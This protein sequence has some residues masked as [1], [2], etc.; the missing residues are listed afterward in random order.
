MVT[1][2][3]PADA[4]SRDWEPVPETPSRPWPAARPTTTEA[5]VERRIRAM[6]AS[7]RWAALLLLLLAL[8]FALLATAVQAGNFATPLHRVYVA[9][10]SAH[11]VLGPA[12]LAILVARRRARRSAIVGTTVMLGLVA[13]TWV[14]IPD[15]GYVAAVP[16]AL[17]ALVVVLLSRP[18]SAEHFRAAEHR[19]LPR[20]RLRRRTRLA[21]ILAALAMLDDALITGGAAYLNHYVHSAQALAR[22]LPARP[23]SSGPGWEGK[24]SGAVSIEELSTFFPHPDSALYDFRRYGAKRAAC[25]TGPRPS[26]WFSSSWSSWRTG[27]PH[28]ATSQ[29]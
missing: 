13:V 2:D 10:I 18:D 27:R 7:V 8:Y 14:L 1:D 26:R 28:D 24:P 16:L 17:G 21:T 5:P 4:P 29:P 23:A 20:H 6:P 11:L 19:D 25:N 12:V 15:F 3:R 22:L 9:T